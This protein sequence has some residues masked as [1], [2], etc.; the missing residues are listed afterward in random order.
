MPFGKRRFTQL[1]YREDR[2]SGD[3]VSWYEARFVPLAMGEA[4]EY[5]TEEALTRALDDNAQARVPLAD[6]EE[7]IALRA[8][9]AQAKNKTF[10]RAAVEA[11]A[12]RG[13]QRV[14]VDVLE[15]GERATVER[16]RKV[17]LQLTKTDDNVHNGRDLQRAVLTL[18]DK[19][20]P[21]G[22]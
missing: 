18:L 19:Y 15:A 9:K 7:Q 5:L 6:L 21:K 14:I 2:S 11:V 3:P 16:L 22:T 10:S 4:D 1:V 8:F 17:V 12:D 20:L 13:K